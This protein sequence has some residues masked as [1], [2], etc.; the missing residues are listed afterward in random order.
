MAVGLRIKF[1]GGTEDQYRAMHSTMNV[2]GDPPEGMIFHSAGP[3]DDGWGIIDFWESRED[4]DRFIEGRLGP[5]NAELGAC[6]F[7]APPDIKQFPVA[8]ITHGRD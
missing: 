6:A 1:A 8:N 2:E 3:I 4:F 7:Q 5:A